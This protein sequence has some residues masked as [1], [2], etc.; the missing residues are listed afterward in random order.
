LL[1]KD[2]GAGYRAQ[3]YSSHRDLLRVF[4]RRDPEA[5]RRAMSD[6]VQQTLDD[7]QRI[8][9]EREAAETISYSV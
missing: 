8:L 7:L 1:E 5:A 3:Q 6:H 2:A 9:K 4:R